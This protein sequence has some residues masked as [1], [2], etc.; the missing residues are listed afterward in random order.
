MVFGIDFRST[1][2][3]SPHFVFICCLLITAFVLARSN[4]LLSTGWPSLLWHQTLIL[5]AAVGLFGTA[6]AVVSAL[7]R[8]RLEVLFSF[9]AI[10]LIVLFCGPAAT[11]VV[12]YF[13]ISAACLARL[14]FLPFGVAEEVPFNLHIVVGWAAFGIVFT[15]LAPVRM[16]FAAVH[17][18]ILAI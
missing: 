16:H 5:F 7:F 13:L 9:Q 17:T 12:L 11:A 15:I 6:I 10:V 1:L 4:V 14:L 8:L 3:Y 18:V 2:R